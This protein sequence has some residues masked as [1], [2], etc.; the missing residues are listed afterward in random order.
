[1]MADGPP[2]VRSAIASCTEC[3]TFAE[4]DSADTR[5]NLWGIYGRS[6]AAGKPELYSAGLRHASGTWN[7]RALGLFL[8]NPQQGYREPRCS[9]LASAT[10]ASER[11]WFTCSINCS[12]PVSR[13]RR[14]PRSREIGAVVPA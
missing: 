5:I 1:M 10:R 9:T 12:R 8:G 2:E 14:L 7:H 6:F 11:A 4:G 3:H 13:D